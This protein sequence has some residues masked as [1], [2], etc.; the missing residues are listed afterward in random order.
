MPLGYQ[1]IFTLPFDQHLDL[2]AHTNENNFATSEA[3]L[4]LL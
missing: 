1:S 4:E 3:K 2:F